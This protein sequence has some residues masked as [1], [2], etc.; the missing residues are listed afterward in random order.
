MTIDIHIM[1]R[2]AVAVLAG[3]VAV[4]AIPGHRF[5]PGFVVGQWVF[6]IA[7]VLVPF[8]WD[9]AL[10]SERLDQAA[11]DELTQHPLACPRTESPLPCTLSLDYVKTRAMDRI[12]RLDFLK[13]YTTTKIERLQ[14]NVYKLVLPNTLFAVV[15]VV[16]AF[17]FNKYVVADAE[18]LQGVIALASDIIQALL[19]C[20][21][22]VWS[23]A[24]AYAEV[25]AQR[26]VNG[27]AIS[28]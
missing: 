18:S 24:W 5:G 12:F 15:T 6:L 27:A 2:A 10:I 17:A 16:V 21:V 19:S 4:W 14:Q 1:A 26:E 8:P 28:A 3:V 23:F 7:F 25:S 13:N 11:A 9:R 22:F 20:I